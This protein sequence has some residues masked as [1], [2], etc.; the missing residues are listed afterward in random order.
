MPN[1]RNRVGTVYVPTGNPDTVNE[2]FSAN[3]QYIAYAPGEN[4][5]DY[6]WNNKRY[7][8][9]YL[10]PATT[11]PTTP[12]QLAYWSNRD[13]YMVTSVPA[14]AIGGATGAANQVAG[15]FGTVPITPGYRC[16]I[17]QRGPASLIAPSGVTFA[18]GETVIANAT[19]AGAADRVAVGTAP[20]YQAIGQAQGAAASGFVTVYM[21]I[22]PI[23]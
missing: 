20:G 21:D 11:T 18:A 23:E 3:L 22:Q 1:N 2:N 17:Q 7:Q 9:V 19:T 12:N 5:T 6:S 14:N 4:G 15:R 13:Q 10:D 8:I 16:H